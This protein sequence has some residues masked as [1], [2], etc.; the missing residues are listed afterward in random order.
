MTSRRIN[1]EALST[2][3]GRSTE[4][5]FHHGGHIVRDGELAQGNEHFILVGQDKLRK[6]GREISRETVST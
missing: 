6:S 3:C 4:G 5:I 1:P 2:R